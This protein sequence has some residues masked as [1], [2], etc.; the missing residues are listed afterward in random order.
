MEVKKVKC[1]GISI[2]KVDKEKYMDVSKSRELLEVKIAN[3]DLHQRN[4]S[5]VKI[6]VLFLLVRKH[7]EIEAK[8]QFNGKFT[9]TDLVMVSVPF[10]TNNEGIDPPTNQKYQI[11]I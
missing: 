6:K 5:K 9:S 11:P 10:I 2:M 4:G 1:K 8:K 7:Q 3:K